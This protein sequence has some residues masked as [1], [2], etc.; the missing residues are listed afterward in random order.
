[1]YVI[2]D[3]RYIL[4]FLLILQ[5]ISRHLACKYVKNGTKFEGILNAVGYRM[6]SK[7]SW[8]S[9]RNYLNCLK[10]RAFLTPVLRAASLF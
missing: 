10:S 1:M 7:A 8:M 4:R 9:R 6:P 5:K 2:C 3:K